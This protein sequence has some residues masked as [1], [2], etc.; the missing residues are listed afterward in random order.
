[1][2]PRFNQQ[3]QSLLSVMG[4]VVLTVVMGGCSADDKELREILKEEL[5]YSKD[6]YMTYPANVST[7]FIVD[8]ISIPNPVIFELE[9]GDYYVNYVVSDSIFRACYDPVTKTFSNNEYLIR[10]LGYPDDDRYDDGQHAIF[11]TNHNLWKLF[12]DERVTYIWDDKYVESYRY[13]YPDTMDLSTVAPSYAWAPAPDSYY[14][15]LSDLEEISLPEG[16]FYRDTINGV[17]VGRF[18]I[19]PKQFLLSLRRDFNWL[20]E[21]DAKSNT[22]DDQIDKYLY[23]E[24]YYLYAEPIYDKKDVREYDENW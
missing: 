21:Y 7:I 20:I 5:L 10:F 6:W 13:S 17:Q 1:M 8:T 23:S 16:P 3:L 19:E 22:F 2:K 11:A 9:C 15:D 12:Y 4:F 24:E 18:E 14:E